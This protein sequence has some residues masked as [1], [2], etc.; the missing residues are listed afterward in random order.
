VGDPIRAGDT[1]EVQ[2][3]TLIALRHHGTLRVAGGSVLV[4]S[5]EEIVNLERGRIYVDLPPGDPIDPA[6]R[7][8]TR[9]GAIEHVGTAFEVLSDE[10]LVRLRVREGEIRW[11]LASGPALAT[12]GTQL[13]VT[14][15]EGL[16]RAETPIDGP[17]WAWAEALAPEY[18]IEGRS[19]VEFL[20]QVGRELGCR[21]EFADPHAREVAARTILHGS[22]KV[23]EPRAALET[24]IA[25][26]SL[27]YEFQGAAIRVH[28]SP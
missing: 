11:W 6:F 17:D 24:V 20:D 7:L 16:A 4:A 26:T 21:V 2:G 22:V 15:M 8:W 1:L 27:T 25:T 18:R 28:S 10:R 14:P 9:E 12:A 23:S 13:S 19:L 5:A 3:S